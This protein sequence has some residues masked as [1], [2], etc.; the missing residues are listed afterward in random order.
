MANWICILARD[1]DIVEVRKVSKS[2]FPNHKNMRIPLSVT[3]EYPVTHWFCT[4]KCSDEMRERIMSVVN[5]SEVYLG[6]P[7]KFL[8]I[9]N[10]K[11]IKK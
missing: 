11:R 3:G 1:E 8:G 9:K 10:L 2:I 4:F 5:L 6:N 7:F